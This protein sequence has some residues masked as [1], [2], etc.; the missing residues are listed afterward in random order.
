MFVVTVEETSEKASRNR[1]QLGVHFK[2]VDGGGGK[3]YSTIKLFTQGGSQTE[4]PFEADS[5]SSPGERKETLVYLHKIN[6]IH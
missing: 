1:L 2:E 3:I 4:T 5:A 6:T